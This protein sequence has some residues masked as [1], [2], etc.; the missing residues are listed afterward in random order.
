[1][2]NI[3]DDYY[4]IATL[5]TKNNNKRMNFEG[6]A[7]EEARERSQANGEVTFSPVASENNDDTKN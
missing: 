2:F 3:I 6:A 4:Y 5:F 7:V 1:M